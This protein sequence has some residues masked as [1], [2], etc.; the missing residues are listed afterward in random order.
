MPVLRRGTWV[1]YLVSLVLVVSACAGSRSEGSAPTGVQS[2]S[3]AGISA[4]T[5][6]DA[7]PTTPSTTVGIAATTTIPGYVTESG[8]PPWMGWHPSV[9]GVTVPESPYPEWQGGDELKVGEPWRYWVTIDGCMFEFMHFNGTW[10]K[11]SDRMYQPGTDGQAPGLGDSYDSHDYPADWDV[12]E[13]PV[14]GGPLIGVD[15]VV[16]LV[17]PTRI[18]ATTL[19]GELIAVYKPTDETPPF[20]TM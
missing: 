19:H 1:F 14:H 6:P 15:G 7:L 9:P 10:W 11:Q 16:T 2:T 17:N 4:T 8:Y 5:S 13:E 12:Y 20:C 18:E 3:T